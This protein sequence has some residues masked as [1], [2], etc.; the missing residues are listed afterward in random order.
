[1]YLVLVAM[2]LAVGFSA[3][4]PDKAPLETVWYD[5]GDGWQPI[6]NPCPEGSAFFCKTTIGSQSNVQLY[7]NQDLNQPVM[8]DEP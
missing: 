4:T 8:Y 3:F 1:M 2:V 7:R 5:L 6:E